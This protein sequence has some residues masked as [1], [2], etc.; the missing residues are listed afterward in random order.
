M[1]KIYLISSYGR[2]GVNLKKFAIDEESIIRLLA[3]ELQD[4]CSQLIEESV[5]IDFVKET[6]KFRCYDYDD[7]T[8]VIEREYEI[9]TIDLI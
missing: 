3:E 8:D 6:V 7:I 5:V 1:I 9:F 2:D 4:I